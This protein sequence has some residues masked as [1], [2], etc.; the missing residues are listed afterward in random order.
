MG[1]PDH[2]EARKDPF[3][4]RVVRPPDRRVEFSHQTAFVDRG[5]PQMSREMSGRDRQFH[6]TGEGP[7]QF[8]AAR[9]ANLTEQAPG[10]DHHVVARVSVRCHV[11]PDHGG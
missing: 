1:P 2:L 4:L 9:L 3:E 11:K 7:C 5:K 8:V 10:Q 6:L